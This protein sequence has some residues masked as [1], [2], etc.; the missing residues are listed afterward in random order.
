MVRVS[1]ATPLCAP[2]SSRSGS[3]NTAHERA[4]RFVV[5]VRSGIK[6]EWE[7]QPGDPLRQRFSKWSVRSGIKSEWESQHGPVDAGADR[8]LVRSGIKSEWESQHAVVKAAHDVAAVCAPASSRSG[9][10][11]PTPT[12]P[13]ATRTGALRHQVGVG[14]STWSKFPATEPVSL[15]APASSRSGSL[16][17]V[18][19]WNALDSDRVR[20]GIKS[21][22]ESQRY[23]A[24]PGSQATPPGALRHQVGVGVS[25]AQARNASSSSMSCAP[26]SSRS[27]SLNSAAARSAARR[28]AVRSG[29]KSEWE[30]QHRPA[31]RQRD[32]G[33]VVRSGIKSEWES[34]PGIRRDPSHGVRGCAPASSRSGSLNQNTVSL[35]AVPLAVRSGIKSE[36]ESQH[37]RRARHPASGGVRSGIKSEWESQQRGQGPSRPPGDCA[38]RHQVGVGVSTSTKVEVEAGREVR[39]G[40]KSEWESQRYRNDV[41]ASSPEGALRH[42]VGVG[43]STAASTRQSTR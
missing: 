11:N 30:S 38:L 43:V 39:S 19:Q 41:L 6:S 16:N 13:P 32:G 22:W 1:Q 25:T 23:G 5:T 27:G 7:S 33:D 26:A 20:S 29:I 2:A 12:R 42:Q 8:D 31:L 17:T 10:L 37:R 9:S 21:E 14:V 36:W 40:I 4:V 3:L 35:L 34:Q 24:Q 28:A 15:C 18:D